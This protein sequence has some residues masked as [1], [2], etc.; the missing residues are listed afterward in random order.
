MFTEPP[1][2]DAQRIV[3]QSFIPSKQYRSQKADAKSAAITA[4][5]M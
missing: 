3:T 4:V 5:S 1:Q 2:S